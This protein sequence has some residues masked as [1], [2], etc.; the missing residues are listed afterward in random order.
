MKRSTAIRISAVTAAVVGAT[1]LTGFA[2]TAAPADGTVAASNGK[3][4]RSVIIYLT[5][6]GRTILNQTETVQGWSDSPLL[7]GTRPIATA[8]VGKLDEGRPLAAAV[9]AEFAEA[10]GDID[11]A[12]SADGKRHF[13]TATYFL[14]GA[15]QDKLTVTQDARLR[16]VNF[17]EYEGKENK[18][19]WSAAVEH[20]GYTID[21]DAAPTA[22]VD[23]TGQNG[24]WQT[25]QGVAI[26]EHGLYGMMAAIKAVADAPELGLPAEDC[27]DVNAR[28]TESLAE[29][30]A[31]AHKTNDDTVLVVSSG[32]S[33][34]CFAGAP[35]MRTVDG[36]MPVMPPTGVPNL[37]VTKVIYQ[38]GEFTIDGPVGSKAYYPQP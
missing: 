28:M 26:A 30:A 1:A 34:S 23:E 35:D 24:G 12:Y 29:I 11:V 27:A 19:L 22:P 14:Q 8:P 6:H 2:A 15:G 36:G 25:M 21:H 3:Q 5:R 10:V 13:E 4:D 37:G 9:G 31:D 38:D 17:G 32:L 33:I 7:V 20:L 16:E 18:E